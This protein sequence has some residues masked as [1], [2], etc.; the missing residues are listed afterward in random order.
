M[1]LTQVYALYISVLTGD[2]LPSYGLLDGGLCRAG[3]G[4]CGGL[5]K[6]R[7]TD[8]AMHLLFNSGQ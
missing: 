5:L 4:L 3:T 8:L 1:Q 2:I 7:Y 6:H